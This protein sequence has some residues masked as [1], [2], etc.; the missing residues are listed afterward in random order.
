MSAA[1]SV[2][3]S[4]R[5]SKRWVATVKTV[6]TFP[7]LGLF[8]KSA[9]TI[10]KSLASKKVSQKGPQ[11]GMRM[12]N[13]YNR[14]GSNLTTARRRELSKAKILLSKRIRAQRTHG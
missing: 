4:R 10:A 11:S 3:G 7:P 6:S 1:R 8:K 9:L 13:Y 14:A 5:S 2:R 12:L